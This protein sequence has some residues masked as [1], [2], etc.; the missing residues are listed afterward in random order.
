MTK[1]MIRAM[2]KAMINGMIK[3]MIPFKE[4]FRQ[5]SYT[6]LAI[7]IFVID[8][9]VKR[10]VLTSFSVNDCLK[11][12]GSWLSLTR[13]NNFGCSFGLH[14]GSGTT[15]F[16]IAFSLFVLFFFVNLKTRLPEH[17]RL[18]KTALALILGGTMGNLLDRLM[19]GSVVDYIQTIAFGIAWPVFNIS[20]VMIVTGVSIYCGICFFSK[21]FDAVHPELNPKARS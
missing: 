1:G 10:I 21:S 12:A 6:I 18:Q 13:V 15:E 14:F 9:I 17:A 4:L 20:D 5:N 8:Q 11:V 19:Y 3:G 2:T 7:S 16:L